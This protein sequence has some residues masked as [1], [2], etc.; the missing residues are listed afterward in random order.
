VIRV[1]KPEPPEILLT[2]GRAR[3]A[4]HEDE[5]LAERAAYEIGDRRFEFARSI[6]AHDSVRETL[7]RAQHHKCCFCESKVRHISDGDVEHFRPKASARQARNAAPEL[8]GYY[9][10]AYEWSN[11][12]FACQSCNQRNKLDLFPL[13]NPEARVR[14]HEKHD[15]IA[16]EQPSFID[17]VVDDPE[18]LLGYRDGEPFAI[19]GNRRAQTTI[20]ALELGRTHLMEQRWETV[21][22]IELLLTALQAARVGTYNDVQDIERFAE[23]VSIRT[24]DAAEFASM[25]RHLVRDRLGLSVRPPVT[26]EDLLAFARGES[27]SSAQQQ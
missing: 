13:E 12:Y 4:K 26:T 14:S 21:K 24:R 23:E 6:Y 3:R 22:L 27:E 9:W 17:P 18:Q 5:F 15:Q 10:L 2:E 7:S 8:P 16:R 11:L 25:T 19:D 1:H 20:Q